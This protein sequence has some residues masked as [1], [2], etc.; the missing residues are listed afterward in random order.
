M[1]SGLPGSQDD[2]AIVA[3][4]VSKR[5]PVRRVVLF[6][7]VV[8]IFDRNWFGRRRSSSSQEEEEKKKDEGEGKPAQTAPGGRPAPPPRQR[9]DRDDEDIDDDDDDLDDEG[10]FTGGDPAK[11][12]EMFWA[13]KDVSFRVPAGTALGVLGGP[14]AG[15]STLLGILGG[16]V[17]PT[18]GRVLVADPVSPLAHA[19]ERS[20]H[21]SAKA[22]S[23]L[24]VILASRLVGADAHLVKHHRDEIEELAAPLKTSHGDPSPGVMMRL[25]IATAVIVPASVL[26]LEEPPGIEEGFMERALARARQQLDNGS[27]VV[28][29]SRRGPLVQ[30][31]CHE[32]IVLDGGSIIDRGAAKGA[33]RSYGTGGDG[34]QAA[35]SA[36]GGRAALAPSRYLSQG[37]K[38]LV[39]PDVPPFNA[40]AALISATLRTDTGRLKRVDPSASEVFIEI[41]F[42]TTMPDVEAHCGVAFRSGAG[43]GPGIRL[44][45]VEPLRFVEPGTYVMTARTPADALRSGVYEV[46]ADAVVANPAERGAHVIARDIGRVHVVGDELDEP[47]PAG[48]PVTSWDGQA[49]W[50]AEAE[51]SIE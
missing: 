49:L 39:P 51:W 15:K 1:N 30:D 28:L 21:T 25:G 22:T 19:I 41:V 44:E 40:F 33:V 36:N 7:P 20:L 2:A 13:L 42:E 27:T 24:D 32:A 48:P 18:E 8:S 5:Y 16:Q 17:F 23:G 3:D 37:R 38:L 11:P 9:E 47:E 50:L 12:G 10:P 14:G 4:G 45:L 43:E 29:A 46:R 6:P 34:V 26:L 31:F 35:G